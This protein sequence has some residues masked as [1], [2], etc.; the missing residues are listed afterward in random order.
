MTIYLRKAYS[1]FKLIFTPIIP[2]YENKKIVI[3]INGFVA[4]YF[5]RQWL[6]IF[7]LNVSFLMVSGIENIKLYIKKNRQRR[8]VQE[9]LGEMK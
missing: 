7:F 3:R 2:F 4:C 9:T 6:W 8:G 5:R 1:I